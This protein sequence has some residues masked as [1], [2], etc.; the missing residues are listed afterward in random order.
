VPVQPPLDTPDALRAGL[1]GARL[2][3][4]TARLDD[5]EGKYKDAF[6]ITPRV[7]FAASCGVPSL[8]EEFP[9]VA[10]S[11]AP[12]AEIATY[13]SPED[14]ADAAAR[15]LGD[16]AA[17][18]AMGRRARSRALREHTWDR[19]VEAFVLDVERKLRRA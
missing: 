11:F 19:R 7:F 16:E 8:I 10:E 15:L 5:A 12:G 2:A 17:R 4:E 18:A 1:N 6:H 9:A 13:R 14:A 3:L